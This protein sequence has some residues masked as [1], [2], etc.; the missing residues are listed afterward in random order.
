MWV[1]IITIAGLVFLVVANLVEKYWYG[2]KGW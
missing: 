2:D 1:V